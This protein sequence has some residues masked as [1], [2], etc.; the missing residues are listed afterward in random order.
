MPKLVRSSFS[1]EAPL[2]EAFEKR[3][4]KRGYENRSEYIRDLFR[5]D[6]IQEEWDDDRICLGTITLLYDHNKRSLS[7]KLTKLQHRHFHSILAATHVHLDHDLCGEAVLVKAKA[8]EIRK[9]ADLLGK[10][11]GV[12]HCTLSLS[13]IGRT[14]PHGHAHRHH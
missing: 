1:M 4:Q 3:V 8:S 6:L 13:S 11:K 14:I 7:D 9:V 5:R 10:Q 2:Y 12:L